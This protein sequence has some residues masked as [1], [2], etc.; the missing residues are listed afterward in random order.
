M[1]TIGVIMLQ[2]HKNNIPGKYFLIE[3]CSIA[4]IFTIED[5]NNEIEQQ[6]VPHKIIKK[7]KL[8]GATTIVQLIFN[9]PSNFKQPSIKI[10]K[11]NNIPVK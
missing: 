5:K 7:I 11:Y 3:A 4:I 6:N 2:M 1:V 10:Y 9:T 8:G